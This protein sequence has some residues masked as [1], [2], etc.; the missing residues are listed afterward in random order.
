MVQVVKIKPC[1]AT[2]WWVHGDH[3]QVT[4][5]INSP[6]G[7]LPCS[8]RIVQPGDWIVD[9]GHT[10]NVVYKDNFEREYK[11]LEDC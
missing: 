11:I 10:L 5:M 8:M 3:P 7:W 9:D 2:Q 4:Y 1:K 6:D